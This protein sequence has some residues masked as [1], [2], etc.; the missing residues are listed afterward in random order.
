VTPTLPS[1]SRAAD[2]SGCRFGGSG[3][4]GARGSLKP[5]ALGLPL[6]QFAERSSQIDTTSHQP[7]KLTLR[8]RFVHN[9]LSPLHIL[10]ILLPGDDRGHPALGRGGLRALSTRLWTRPHGEG[11]ERE[12]VGIRGRATPALTL[13]PRLPMRW[14]PYDIGSPGSNNAGASGSQSC[15]RPRHARGVNSRPR[16]APE[17]LP[18]MT[19]ELRDQQDDELTL[20][21][22]TY[23][24][25]LRLQELLVAVAEDL[26]RLAM[27]HPDLRDR[28]SERA[29]RLRRH[30][31]RSPFQ[32]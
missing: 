27:H 2:E 23:R 25:N 5:G 28:F 4:T 19:I 6:L 21:Q 8:W 11:L 16:L 26:E 3:R 15:D 7:P 9:A 32:P 10:Q 1:I 31:H 12:R 22:R 24:D 18:L 17:Y 14:L 13:E 20:L 30:L 29:M